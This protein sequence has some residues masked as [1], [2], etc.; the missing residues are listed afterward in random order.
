MIN[1]T[2]NDTEILE[3][4]FRK[5]LQRDHNVNASKS[6]GFKNVAERNYD[7]KTVQDLMTTSEGLA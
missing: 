5:T 7:N 2:G 3:F 4:M 1:D 6:A